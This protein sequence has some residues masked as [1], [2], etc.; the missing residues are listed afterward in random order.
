[1]PCVL[2]FFWV[3]CVTWNKLLTHPNYSSSNCICYCFPMIFHKSFPPCILLHT[4]LF[5]M[6]QVTIM[7]S[8]GPFF[9]QFQNSGNLIILWW[10]LLIILTYYS[11]QCSCC[12]EGGQYF[13]FIPSEMNKKYWRIR[14]V[15][16]YHKFLQTHGHPWKVF[17]CK[18][19]SAH[20]ETC[21]RYPSQPS[22][23]VVSRGGKD[24]DEIPSGYIRWD[25][26][27]TACHAMLQYD[28]RLGMGSNSFSS[29]S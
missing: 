16:R 14:T 5:A 26:E 23:I 8:D 17:W 13:G 2:H 28:V 27:R 3:P 6:R 21:P 29:Y 18:Y 11:T 4:V 22:S 9:S 25:Y 24:F 15:L 1:M 20:W 7:I 19:R 10:C 12:V